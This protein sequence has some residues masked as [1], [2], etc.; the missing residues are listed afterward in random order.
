MSTP[1][2]A[3]LS[4]VVPC[5]NE[6][7]N[8]KETIDDLLHVLA[9]KCP[10]LEIIIVDD[11]STDTTSGIADDLKNAHSCIRVIRH[12][13]PL[14]LGQSYLEAAQ[15]ARGEFFILCPGDH[16]NSARSILDIYRARDGV[17]IVIPFPA[18]AGIRPWWRRAISWVYVRM[19]NA[20][21]GT[22]VRYYNGTVLHRTKN[23]KGLKLNGLGFGYQSEI[24]VRLL[25]NGLSYRECAVAL[26][27]LSRDQRRT[28]LFRLKNLV[29][30]IETLSGIV[31]V[32]VGAR[33]KGPSNRGG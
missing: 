30:L 5:L 13:R 11:G 17:D 31:P 33:I 23:L 19:I 15:L 32:A 20:L 7:A 16:E 29:S 9:P 1:L 4:V 2:E 10:D 24:I 3:S 21:A 25:C 28:H 27:E 8:L 18:N 6:A 14:G 12:E 22:S 26:N